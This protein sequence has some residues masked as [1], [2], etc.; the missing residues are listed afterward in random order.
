MTIKKY[1]I[2]AD[3]VVDNLTSTLE[4]VPLSANQGREL[5]A[6]IDA[7][8]GGGLVAKI[9]TSYTGSGTITPSGII[10]VLKG[11]SKTVSFAPSTGY[12]ITDVKVDGQSEGRITSKTFANVQEDHT[13]DVTFAKIRFTVTKTASGPGSIIGE[14]SPEYGSSQTYTI[15][16]NAGA[17]ITGV[18]VDGTAQGAVSSVSLSNITANHTI[19]ASFVQQY[20]ITAS[21]GA[22]GSISP[23]GSQ[24]YDAGSTPVYTI[25]ANKGYVINQV[26][27]DGA[28]VTV[29]GSTYT[30]P[31]LAANHTISVTFMENPQ[32]FYTFTINKATASTSPT[33]CVSYSEGV[34]NAAEAYAVA[35]RWVVPTVVKN[36]QVNY[37]LYRQNLNYKATDETGDTSAGTASNLTGADGDVCAS[38]IPLWWKIIEDNDSRRTM[39]I[40]DGPFDGAV[41][42]HKFDGII[43]KYVHV[44]MFHSTQQACNSVYSTTAKPAAN[45]THDNFRYSTEGRGNTYGMMTYLTWSMLDVI[46]TFASGSVDG[47]TTIGKDFTDSSNSA[48]APVSTTAML[49]ADGYTES[50]KADGKTSLMYL[51]VANPWGSV[52]DWVAGLKVDGATTGVVTDQKDA[53]GVTVDAAIPSSWTTFSSPSVSGSHIKDIVN[54]NAAPFFPKTGGAS[55]TTYFCDYGYSSNGS[56]KRC[57]RVGGSWNDGAHAGPFFAGANYSSSVA[58]ANFGARLQVLDV[59]AA[60]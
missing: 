3:D 29:S 41:S 54:N 50:T 53:R 30:F 42:A 48:A 24:I 26:K 43:R 5:K 52:L 15:T 46:W 49:T 2:T 44:G 38:F 45:I 13:I 58:Y 56:G 17:R 40:S 39:R 7:G 8:G 6:L 12:E 28:A 18:T 4:D 59:N 19:T 23:A 27:V 37:Y 11:D 33:T 57:G 34:S 16:P 22:N 20:T 14:G 60:A 36:G 55:S 47:Q 32:N 10:A 21:A 51:F 35:K 1:I 25:T 31:A 9:V